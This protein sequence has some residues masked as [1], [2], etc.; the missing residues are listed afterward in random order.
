M[1]AVWQ[2]MSEQLFFVHHAFKFKIHAFVLMSN[3]YHLIVSTPLANLPNG[4]AW[5]NRETSRSLTRAGNRINLTYGARHFRA[6][7]SSHHYFLNAYKYL[8]YNPVHAKVCT[9]VLEY[10]FSTLQGLLGKKPVAFPIQEDTTLF[11]D[12][13]GALAWLNRVPLEDNWEAVRKA[14][15]KKEFKL[16]KKDSRPHPLEIDTL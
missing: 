5:F 11:G 7:L 14:L 13:E 4:M 8:Y 9:N 1:D 3:H 6:V 2:I 12:L 16:A 10:P 15:K